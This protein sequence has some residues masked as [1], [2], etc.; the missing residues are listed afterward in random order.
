[1]QVQR[2]YGKSPSE[3]SPARS[4]GVSLEVARKKTKPG[5]DGAGGRYVPTATSRAWAGS[6]ALGN[7][8]AV[9]A[10]PTTSSLLWLA[11]ATRGAGRGTA[12]SAEGTPCG[13]EAQRGMMVGTGSRSEV[14]SGDEAIFGGTQA[15]PSRAT[16][17]TRA[18]GTPYPPRHHAT[19]HDASARDILEL[20]FTG[21][22]QSTGGRGAH[23]RLG[24]VL[25][26]AAS[27]IR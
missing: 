20:H 13:G 12:S 9:S 25:S 21:L 5:L 16:G 27:R 23:A 3:T 10:A 4:A 26:S 24:S 22:N 6:G 2:K 18:A 7:S 15:Q 1:M 8:T 14:K 17:L 19:R 11:A